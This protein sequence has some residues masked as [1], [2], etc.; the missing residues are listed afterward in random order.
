MKKFIFINQKIKKFNKTIKIDGDKSIS[1]R[2]LIFAALSSGKSN[3]KN[4]LESEDIFH[5]VETLKKLGVKITKKKQNYIVHGVGINKFKF[6]KKIELNAGNSGTLARLIIAV[7]IN[8]PYKIKLTGDK[9]LSKRDFGRIIKP[10]TNFGVEFFPKK[11]KNLPLSFKN[12]NKIKLNKF[13]EHKGSAQVKSAIM[14]ASLH[15][16]DETEIIAKKSRD[17][18]ERFFKFLKIPIKI[19][20]KANYDYIKIRGVEKLKKFNYNVPSDISSSLFL[21]ALTVLSKKSELTLRNVN[22]NYSRL[23]AIEILK[24]MGVKIK[25]RNKKI[26]KGEEIADIYVRSP[27]KLNPIN[28]PAEMNSRA[29]DEFLIIFL[30]AAKADGTSY[31]KDLAELNQKESPRLKIAAKFLSMIGIMNYSTEDK[32]K[33]IGNPSL[34]LNKNFVMKGFLKD[35]RVFMMSVIAAL[36]LGGNW[37]IYDPESFK[38][39]FPSFLRLIKTLGAKYK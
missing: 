4:L 34:E 33:I 8:S 7:L 32:I 29:I 14:L 19:K 18:T 39:S 37:K 26:Y 27:K 6:K 21:I 35:H 36:T 9:S 13:Y 15:F 17:H 5:T 20:K 25:F 2:C 12:Y 10:I 30:I 24:K 38:T 11:K 28:C 16:K 23:G 1:I 3:I 31:F 22:I